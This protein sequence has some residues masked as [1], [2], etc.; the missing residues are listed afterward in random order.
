MLVT[1]IHYYK[2]LSPLPPGAKDPN[3]AHVYPG[4]ACYRQTTCLA[5]GNTISSWKWGYYLPDIGSAGWTFT[6]EGRKVS[7]ATPVHMFTVTCMATLITTVRDKETVSLLKVVPACSQT[8][9]VNVQGDFPRWILKHT[10]TQAFKKK[11]LDNMIFVMCNI[12][13]RALTSWL[14][15][16]STWACLKLGHSLRSLTFQRVNL[17]WAPISQ[18]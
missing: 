4:Q 13:L 18:G 2:S 7:K 8:T 6:Y 1:Y 17:K 11:Y 16:H 9:F 14:W 3:W 5:H 12:A 10:G 15:D